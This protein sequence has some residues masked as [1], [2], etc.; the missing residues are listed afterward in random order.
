[1]EF[2]LLHIIVLITFFIVLIKPKG[3]KRKLMW[4]AI[5]FFAFFGDIFITNIVFYYNAN[6]YA[7]NIYLETFKGNSLYIGEY[8]VNLMDKERYKISEYYIGG[9]IG[10]ILP[11][12]YM[13]SLLEDRKSV[14]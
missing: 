13:R 9:W 5:W 2:I 12:F 4:F 10:S 14:V 7:T 6:K 3:F 8:K 1:M 11:D